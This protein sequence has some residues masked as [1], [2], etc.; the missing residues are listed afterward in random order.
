MIGR[1]GDVE[2]IEAVPESSAIGESA[3]N[4]RAERTVQAFEDLLRTLKSALESRMQAKLPVMHPAM[5][6]MIEHVAS[7][8]NRYC[9][10]DDGV[11]PYQAI[12]GTRST[13]KIVEF[14]DKFFIMF[15]RP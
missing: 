5:K 6:W 13:L 8:M 10:N 9:V 4:G 7:T 12:H 14:C 15:R 3:S 1:R 11:T 2:D